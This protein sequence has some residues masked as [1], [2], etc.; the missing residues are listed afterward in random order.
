MKNPV[1]SNPTRINIIYMRTYIYKLMK[2]GL[3]P[4]SFFL[5]SQSSLAGCFPSIRT[6]PMSLFHLRL[7]FVFAVLSSFLH[8]LPR[9]AF[10][11]LLLI[12]QILISHLLLFSY[13]NLC[14]ISS[15]LL[16]ESRI[17]IA[18][19]LKERHLKSQNFFNDS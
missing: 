7:S 6:S 9:A 8:S 2:L 14:R 15:P 1:Q 16:L 10:H 12:S 19:H 18:S 5:Y 4:P 13:L 3:L 11:L 17:C